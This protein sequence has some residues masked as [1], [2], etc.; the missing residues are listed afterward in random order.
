MYIQV[1]PEPRIGRD[2]VLWSCY[3]ALKKRVDGVKN[4]RIN[5]SHLVLGGSNQ[6]KKD[7][8][9]RMLVLDNVD[10]TSVNDCAARPRLLMPVV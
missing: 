5:S 4:K 7:Y 9:G 8:G 1:C 6:S 10:A 3:G 2:T